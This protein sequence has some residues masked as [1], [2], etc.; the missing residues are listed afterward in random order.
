MSSDRPPR[1]MQRQSQEI[2]C[3]PE[4]FIPGLTLPVIYHSAYY[5][6][7]LCQSWSVEELYL[8]YDCSIDS[9]DAPDF[10]A[11][12]K[13]EFLSWVLTTLSASPAARKMI[14][15]AARNG[16]QIALESLSGPDF[17]LDVPE[18]LI[19]IDN[20][21]MLHSALVRSEYF[22]NNI[23]VSAIRALRDVWQEKRHGAF[24]ETYGPENVLTLERVRAADMD[25][26]AVLCAWELRSEGFTGLWRHMIGGQDGD[27]ALRY[28]TTLERSPV[29]AYNGAALKAAFV[30]WF[31]DEIRVKDCDHETLS[32]LDEILHEHEGQQ[33]IFGSKRLHAVG[34]EVLS[35]LPDK[36]AYLQGFGPEILKDP[37]FA[38]MN[39][40]INQAHLM[41]ILHDLRA[42]R[43]H[44]IPF[45]SASLA[46]KIFPNGAFTEETGLL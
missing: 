39:D 20:N 11:R 13:R 28:S 30:Q 29:T 10:A 19:V 40:E 46:A 9:I 6:P 1:D 14:E 8:A 32:M 38:G 21:N 23:L 18:K 2:H 5:Q 17:H 33:G 34:V 3:L 41:Q 35:C 4:D 36:T 22:R 31:R 27:I 7:G 43:V 42:V 16:W 37:L 12:D 45:R 15:E 25:V 26:M 24:D 44:G